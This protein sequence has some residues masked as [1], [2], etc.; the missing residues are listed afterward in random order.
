MHDGFPRCVHG[1]LSSCLQGCED[2]Y[3]WAESDRVMIEM[4]DEVLMMAL[5]EVD[6]EST[7][8]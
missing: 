2:A 8:G 3:R 5:E 4:L 1:W 6:G 7:V